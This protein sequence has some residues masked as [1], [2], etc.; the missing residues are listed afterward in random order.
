MARQSAQFEVSLRLDTT[1]MQREI[2]R[3]TEEVTRLMV[4]RDDAAMLTG[5]EFDGRGGDRLTATLNFETNEPA[6]ALPEQRS[7]MVRG[8]K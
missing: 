5:V 3:M 8:R 4:L 2:R 7:V 6:P 1:A